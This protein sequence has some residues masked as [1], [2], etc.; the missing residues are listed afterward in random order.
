MH[1]R[2]RNPKDNS[3]HNYGGRGI[4]VCERWTGPDG[5]ANF[6]A[7]MGERPEGTWIERNNNNGNYEPANCRWATIME[8][9]QNRRQRR[10]TSSRFPGVSWHKDTQK[11]QATDTTYHYIGLFDNELDAARAARPEEGLQ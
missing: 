1:R 2:C 7:D 11:W 6:L 4:A 9:M 3:Y 8:Q 10:D 5:F